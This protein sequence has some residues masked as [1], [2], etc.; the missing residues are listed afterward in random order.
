M[1]CTDFSRYHNKAVDVEAAEEV[2]GPDTG[3]ALTNLMPGL[4]LS[5]EGVPARSFTFKQPS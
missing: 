4:R 2:R 5:G 3:C 1:D